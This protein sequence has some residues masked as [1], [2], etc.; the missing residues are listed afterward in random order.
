MNSKRNRVVRHLTPS[1]STI[2]ATILAAS[3]AIVTTTEA[4]V[5]W[6]IPP[7]VEQNYQAYCGGRDAPLAAT[8]HLC[9]KTSIPIIKKIQKTSH[10]EAYLSP[11]GRRFAL[12]P[13][14]EDTRIE[15]KNYKMLVE[16]YTPPSFNDRHH[17]ADISFEVFGVHDPNSPRRFATVCHP[18]GGDHTLP[19]K[20]PEN[21][22]HSFGQ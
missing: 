10:F 6:S 12:V 4:V 15:T 14:A 19:E 17:C 13:S 3:I 7:T 1:T 21:P 2:K 16:F 5:G 20:A 22:R 8:K 18:D 9:V 11:E